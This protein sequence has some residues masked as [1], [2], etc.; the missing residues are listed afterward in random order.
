MSSIVF[1]RGLVQ[2]LNQRK[3][4][5]NADRERMSLLCTLRA[6]WSVSGGVFGPCPI[7]V[8]GG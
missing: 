8:R 2:W 6:G 7:L 4:V 1:K 3:W 5:E